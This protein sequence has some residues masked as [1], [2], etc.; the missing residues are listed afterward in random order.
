MSQFKPGQHVKINAYVYDYKW[1]GHEE[2]WRK[3]GHQALVVDRIIDLSDVGEGEWVIVEY[4]GQK[5]KVRP[6]YL[7]D[8]TYP[9]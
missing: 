1:V 9:Q 7:W 4:L 8:V 3:F 6:S 2:L 5:A